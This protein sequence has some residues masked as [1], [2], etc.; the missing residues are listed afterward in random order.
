MNMTNKNIINRDWA[1][2]LLQAALNSKPEHYSYLSDHE[3]CKY[4]E[5]DGTPSCVVGVALT[6]V[7]VSFKRNDGYTMAGVFD[8]LVE[9]LKEVNPELEITPGALILLI[10]AQKAQDEGVTYGTVASILS[11]LSRVVPE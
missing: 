7:G 1:Y 3:T 11:T 4:L 10:A 9:D 8:M 2:Q 5:D 6:N